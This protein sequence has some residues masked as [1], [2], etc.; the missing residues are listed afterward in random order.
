[1]NILL[2][3]IDGYVGWPVALKLSK[4][5]PND[6]IIGVDNMGRRKWVEET[7]SV[8]AIPI[9]SMENRIATAKK[10]GFNNISFIQGDLTDRNFVNQLF[11]VYSFSTVIH[12]A[13][14][15]SAPYSHINGEKA[16]YTQFN[17]NQSTRNLL[18][19]I[20]EKKIIDKCHFIVT[21]TTGVYGAPKFTIPEGFILAENKGENDTIPFPGMAGSW[22][23][24]SK[25]NDINNLWLANRLWNLSITDLRT[26]I[27]YGTE[28]QET[29]LDPSLATRFDFDFYFGVVIN[30]FAAMALA[31]YPITVYGKGNQ[32]KPQISLE[33]CAQSIVNAVKMKKNK[34]F[35]VYNQTTELVS[36]IELA[37]SIKEEAKKFDLKVDIQNIPNPRVEN[38]EHQMTMDTTNFTSLLPKTKYNIQSGVYQILNSLI[39]Y[40][41]TIID[42][43]DRFMNE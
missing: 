30:R 37:I 22:Y 42:Y 10:Y 41:Q 39:P 18:W 33:D 20:K 27:V 11:D 38:E 2:T 14:Q 6:R 4:E 29:I 34:L 40:K 1:M 16:N 24:M 21:T 8:T 25:S 17:N 43:K 19:S 13:S 26:S 23:H 12:V 5:F 3:G 15:P 31:G 28:T 36:V 7:G 35:N 9:N 32:K